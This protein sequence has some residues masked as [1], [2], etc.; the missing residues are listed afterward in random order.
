MS[1]KKKR[2][3][4]GLY[5]F[6]RDQQ[7]EGQA[8]FDLD[9]ELARKEE[10]LNGFMDDLLMERCRY[11]ARWIWD[12]T[13]QPVGTDDVRVLLNIPRTTVGGHGKDLRCFGALFRNGEWAFL[14]D[15]ASRLKR[16]HARP[17]GR[18]V[19][20]EFLYRFAALKM[21]AG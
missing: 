15:S 16:G 18:W 9:G 4:P 21:A 8:E 3:F 5:R 11:A 6:L 7:V 19:P 13:Q 1:K 20:K 2:E 10:I 12:N 17:I 14:K